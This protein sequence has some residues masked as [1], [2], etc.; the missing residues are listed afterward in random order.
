MSLFRSLW[1]NINL[2]LCSVAAKPAAPSSSTTA[3]KSA[4][5][6]KAITISFGSLK[7]KPKIFVG[8][9]FFSTGKKRMSMFKKSAPKS[10][11]RPTSAQK[12]QSGATTKQ[13]LPAPVTNLQQKPPAKVR[14]KRIHS[15]GSRIQLTCTSLALTNSAKKFDIASSAQMT[16]LLTGQPQW[17]LIFDWSRRG[18]FWWATSQE[19]KYTIRCVEKLLV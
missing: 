11:S 9:A 13:Q 16:K 8:A 4:E 12:A 7:P 17:V 3:A 19:E 6:K 15:K 18:R 2:W 14:V 10:T 5:P 1:N